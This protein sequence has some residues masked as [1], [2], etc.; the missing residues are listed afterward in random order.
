[1]NRPHWKY[2]RNVR[3]TSGSPNEPIVGVNHRAVLRRAPENSRGAARRQTATE[4]HRHS[5]RLHAPSRARPQVTGYVEE[6]TRRQN[7]RGDS[8]G[9]NNRG[10]TIRAGNVGS[11]SLMGAGRPP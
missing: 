4:T 2:A 5:P 10:R 8:A 3:K 6:T 7:R 1:V 9:V 11:P